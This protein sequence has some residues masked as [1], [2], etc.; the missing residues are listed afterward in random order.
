M[1]KSV[2]H[3]FKIHRKVIFG[4]PAVVVQNMF[5]KT[6]KSLNAVDVI[7]RLSID[8]HFRVT[9]PMMFS[10]TL[11]GVVTPKRVGV[12][13][14]SLPCFLLDNRHQLFFTDMFHH[15]RIDPSVAL[16]K[17]ENNTFASC[18]SRPRFPFRLPPK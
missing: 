3:L 12:I 18:A 10:E 8:E 2:L 5:C 11:E 7:S 9:D 13:D 16:Q 6:P 14:R 15:A 17:A 1:I 4:N